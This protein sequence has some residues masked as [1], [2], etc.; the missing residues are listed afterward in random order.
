MIH[1]V[2]LTVHFPSPDRNGYPGARAGEMLEYKDLALEKAG[3]MGA[4][5]MSG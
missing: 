4:R 5:S 3:R 2:K 1:K